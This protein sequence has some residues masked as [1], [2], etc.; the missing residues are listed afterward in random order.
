MVSTSVKFNVLDGS[1]ADMFISS[2]VAQRPAQPAKRSWFG[3]WFGRKDDSSGGPIKAKLGEENSFYYDPNLKKWVNKKDPNSANAAA[4][5]TPPPPKGPA[6][7]SRS[8]SGSSSAPP[9]GG[10]L[11]ASQRPPSISS[12]PSTGTG[13]PPS[14]SGSPA[15]SPPGAP[16]PGAPNG[17]PRSVSTA[18]A[19][20]ATPPSSS[21]GQAPPPRPSLSNASSIDDLLGAPQARKGNTMR[22]KK[23]G[24]GYVD[25]MAK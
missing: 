19:P 3:S 22:G 18:S 16:P 8:A 10:P 25:V 24:R 20:G 9:A 6:P 1:N 13:A 14:R 21:S 7:P 4:R 2:P 17:P 15:L 11:M 23:K 12:R 5:A